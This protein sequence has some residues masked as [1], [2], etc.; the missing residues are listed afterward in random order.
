MKTLLN[1]NRFH[2][3]CSRY[4]WA[5]L[6]CRAVWDYHNIIAS[7]TV[8]TLELGIEY[9]WKKSRPETRKKN[10]GFTINRIGYHTG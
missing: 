2:L 8:L 1:G 5:W 4:E 7:V 10:Y 3:W 9:I 6:E